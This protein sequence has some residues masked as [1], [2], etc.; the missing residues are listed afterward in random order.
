MALPAPEALQYRWEHRVG[1][2]WRPSGLEA[3]SEL[4]PSPL[5]FV[6]LSSE[7]ARQAGHLDCSFAE[8]QESSAP[9]LVVVLRERLGLER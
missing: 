4:V 9:L 6:R 2:E 8:K 3:V 5:R 7:R 1:E